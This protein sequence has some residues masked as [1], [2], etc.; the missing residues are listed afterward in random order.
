MPRTTGIGEARE[1]VGERAVD[2]R[3]ADLCDGCRVRGRHRRERQAL[4][5]RRHRA[6]ADARMVDRHEHPAPCGVPARLST[7]GRARHVTPGCVRLSSGRIRHVEGE[8]L[9][10]VAAAREAE[11]HH[12]PVGECG[13]VR[14]RDR[15]PGVERLPESR[16]VGDVAGHVDRGRHARH[17]VAAALRRATTVDYTSP[18]RAPAP[19]VPSGAASRGPSGPAAKLPRA[20]SRYERRTAS[21]HG[22]AHLRHARARLRRPGRRPVPRRRRAVRVGRRVGLRLGQPARAP[23]VD[24]RVPA[25]ADRARQRGGGGHRAHAHPDERRAPAAVPPDPSRRGP[26]GA[27]PDRGRPPP[28]HRRR[29]VPGRRVRAV[30]SRHQAPPVPHGA[31]RRGVEAGVD[32]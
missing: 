9:A 18:R 21:H 27:R 1:P 19:E 2:E 10:A 16:G 20:G 14:E 26:R 4:R 12:R 8:V 11:A 15:R 5:F 6:L 25:V 7:A 22:V 30:R 17:H 23:R 28:A 24:R 29:R 32:R 31:R 13:R 3:V